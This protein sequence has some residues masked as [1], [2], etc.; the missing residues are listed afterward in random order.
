[1]R[2]RDT[3]LTLDQIQFAREHSLVRIVDDEAPLRD[4]LRFVLEMEGWRVADYPSAEAFLRGDSPSNPGCV[5]L[6]VRM[7]G[8]TGIQAQAVMNERGI[9][10]PVIFL[11][12]HG[13]VDMAVL[14]LQDGAVDFI[15]KPIDNER[16]L[17]SIAFAAFESASKAAGL[18][19]RDAVERVA[20]LTPRERQIAELIAAG[21]LNREIAERFGSAVRTVEVHRANVL[22][23]LGVKTP[24]EIKALLALADV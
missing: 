24:E 4:A 11:T 21:L 20:T 9:R 15:Q 10:L 6:D 23:K 3:Q 1:M 2:P 17:A 12:G 14:A 7:P 16:L 5:V 22:R 13:D 8:M 19:G 18:P